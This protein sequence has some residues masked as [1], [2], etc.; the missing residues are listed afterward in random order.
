MG[1]EKLWNLFCTNH[2]VSIRLHK[3][4]FW[5]WFFCWL[6]KHYYIVALFCRIALCLA[7]RAILL[8]HA[9]WMLI[10]DDN[11][12]SYMSIRISDVIAL[13][14]LDVTSRTSWMWITRPF[15]LF[16]VILQNVD[17]ISSELFTRHRSMP[18]D[19]VQLLIKQGIL[20]LHTSSSYFL[21]KMR[22][23]LLPSKL[24]ALSYSR[25]HFF[26]SH[27]RVKLSLFTLFVLGSLRI[28][29]WL[30]VRTHLFL[31]KTYITKT[32]FPTHKLPILYTK[33][34]TFPLNNFRSL[35]EKLFSFV[36]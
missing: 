27:E 13:T 6:Y 29:W 15:Q 33:V 5:A 25:L 3:L 4:N 19:S 24:R 36:W 17:K 7:M 14:C 12:C 26:P 32:C 16:L 22:F 9:K 21:L 10:I 1:L 11:A 34:P 30:L 2:L 23:C 31:G 18:P 20:W 35:R 8:Q 28:P